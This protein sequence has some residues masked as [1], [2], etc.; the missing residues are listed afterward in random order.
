MLKLHNAKSLPSFEHIKV[1]LYF[2][3]STC[4]SCNSYQLLFVQHLSMQENKMHNQ[5]LL[6]AYR[7]IQL[8]MSAIAHL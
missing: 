4:Q 7:R 5:I 3:Y 8:M 2:W 6:A 1:Y